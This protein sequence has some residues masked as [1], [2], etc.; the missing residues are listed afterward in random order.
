[1]SRKWSQMHLDLQ[2]PRTFSFANNF[3]NLQNIFIFCER[4]FQLTANFKKFKR[5]IVPLQDLMVTNYIKFG[6]AVHIDY[7]KKNVS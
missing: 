4:I 7:L 2:N 1:M 5:D 6:R 3:R